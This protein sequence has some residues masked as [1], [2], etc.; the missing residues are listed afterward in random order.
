MT[1]KDCV[2]LV[3]VYRT[4]EPETQNGLQVL[5]ERGYHVELLLGSSQID[6][7]RS[8]MA[9]DALAAGY[10]ETMWID[11]DTGFSPDD[12]ETLRAHQLPLV[13]GLYPTKDGKRFACK[14][15]AGDA[16]ATFGVGGGLREI[17]YAGMGFTL[18]RAEAYHAIQAQHQ[19]PRCTGGYEGKEVVPYFMPALAQNG[20]GGIDYLSEDFSLSHRAREAGIEV[21]ADTTIRLGHVGRHVVT[22]EDMAPV[23]RL[24]TLTIEFPG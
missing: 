3:P 4:L 15:L 7:A 12:V 19:L 24:A 18:I 14:F 6:L 20:R 22:W 8:Q 17:L 1:N 5:Q 13:C 11:A 9:T 2:I 16:G 21:M 10:T 23:Q